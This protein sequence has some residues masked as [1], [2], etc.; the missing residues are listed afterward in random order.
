MDEAVRRGAQR[1]GSAWGPGLTQIH[2]GPPILTLIA[3][4]VVCRDPSVFQSNATAD[5]SL[6]HQTLS[7]FWGPHRLWSVML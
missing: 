5:M 7:E 4:S 2:L 3:G 1:R 6:T